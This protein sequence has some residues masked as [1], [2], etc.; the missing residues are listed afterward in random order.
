MKAVHH[1]DLDIP[2]G[3]ET[4]LR[5]PM[6]EIAKTGAFN[7]DRSAVDVQKSPNYGT[8]TACRIQVSP[9]GDGYWDFVQVSEDIFLTITE[10]VYRRTEEI[11]VQGE[12]LF[13][14]R[15]LVSGSIRWLNEDTVAQD[16]LSHVGPCTVLSY[17][18]FGSDTHYE[19]EAD[20]PVS[21]MTLHCKKQLVRRI[22]DKGVYESVSGLGNPMSEE[23]LTDR[24]LPLTPRIELCINEI[25]NS[26]YAGETRLFFARAKCIELLCIVAGLLEEQEEPNPST[27]IL[28]T[29]SRK[30]VHRLHEV[31][32]LVGNDLTRWY[33]SDELCHSV[34]LNT[35]KLKYGF[36]R[37][38]GKTPYKYAVDI[39]M[40]SAFKILKEDN[41]TVSE[42]AYMMG[43]NYPANFTTAF[44]KYF[45][46]TPQ[47]ARGQMEVVEKPDASQQGQGSTNR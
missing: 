7:D 16:E 32:D 47:T 39:R 6:A 41:L 25:L 11:L 42:V 24:Q 8:G 4:I 15:F 23:Q 38:F 3:E 31:R 26:P 19:L 29:L 33:S 10:A 35:K 2:I 46:F 28:T 9:S 18:P 1:G 27:V 45:G 22:F 44:K 13:K 21:M 20:E 14:L 17:H 12:D 40:E 34:G 36:K 37:L 43:Y 30:E 5:L